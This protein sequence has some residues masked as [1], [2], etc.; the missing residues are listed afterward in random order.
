MIIVA[1]WK[2]NGTKEETSSWTS[3][4]SLSSHTII[5]CPP[6]PLLDYAVTLSKDKCY[7]GGQDCHYESSGAYTGFTSPTLLKKIGCN[8]VILGHSERRHLET[9]GDI[10]K[11]ARA[12]QEAGLTPIICVGE[13]RDL[14]TAQKHLGFVEGQVREC[15]V[16]L[17][18]NYMIAYEPLWAIGTG[19]VCSL[20]DIEG[21]HSMIKSLVPV[22]VLYGGSVK[23]DNAKDILALSKV[24]GLLVGGASLSAESFNRIIS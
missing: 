17:K 23:P 16:D 12:A 1:N 9:N 22:E 19:E 11:K 20:D 6:F 10:Q 18:N 2:M 4:I 8:Y 7:V 15:T 24:D 3:N 5:L 13:S 14:R 21:M